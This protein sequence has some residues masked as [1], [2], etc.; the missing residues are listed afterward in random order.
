M[1]VYVCVWNTHHAVGLLPAGSVAW[2]RHA[3]V[4]MSVTQTAALHNEIV[5]GVMF[6]GERVAAGVLRLA[7]TRLTPQETDSQ[8]GDHQLVLGGRSEGVH[9]VRGRQSSVDHLEMGVKNQLFHFQTDSQQRKYEPFPF[10]PF[11][12]CQKKQ[13]NTK[14]HLVCSSSSAASGKNLSS[15]N[16]NQRFFFCH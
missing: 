9:L 7:G 11:M 14:K 2:R 13:T 8:V 15:V 1:C 6:R 12:V 10:F 4:S 16:V 3:V 5:D